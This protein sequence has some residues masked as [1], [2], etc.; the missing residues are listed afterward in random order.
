MFQFIFSRLPLT[1]I[2]LFCAR[3]A[4][5][6]IRI[7]I[8]TNHIQVSRDNIH[9][10]LDLSEGI[11]L[12]I[13][14]FGSYQS[15]IF[16]NTYYKIPE[17]AVIFDIGASMGC[18]TLQFARAASNGHAFAFE[19][20]DF[21]YK[22][23]L[24]NIDLNPGLKPRITPVKRFASEKT[25]AAPH[26]FAIA[27][28]RTDCLNSKGHPVHGGVQ[29]NTSLASSVTL[30]DFCRENEIKKVTLIKIDTEGHELSVIKGARQILTQYK[31][32]I[33]FE[34][35]KY[36]LDEQKIKFVEFYDIL[37]DCGYRLFAL[38]NGSK[39]TR[40]NYSDIIPKRSTIDII[41][42]P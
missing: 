4:Y 25:M 9:Y 17:D 26:L 10:M 39:I 29:R 16:K 13:F 32:V 36:M 18:M 11:D 33:I 14:M 27:S 31:P 6:F 28:W 8:R 1:R 40:E 38:Q 5:L 15:H 23:L 42:I 30:D 7:F 12:S 35:G 19:P 20:A 34:V 2:K 22:K 37:N 24:K 21:A 3:I 41:A